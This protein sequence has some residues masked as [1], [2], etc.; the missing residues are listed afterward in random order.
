MTLA[1]VRSIWSG[2]MI[3]G[4]G[5]TDLYFFGSTGD[6]GTFAA[7]VRGL[8]ADLASA[9][10][11]GTTVAIDPDVFNIDEAT[12]D[13]I[14]IVTL[15][16]PPSPVTGT[17]AGEP[18]PPASQG[19][20]QWRTSG[21]VANRRVRGRTFLPALGEGGSTLGVPSSGTI[22]LVEDAC[23][24]FLSLA[25]QPMVWSRPV[26]GVRPGSM[27]DVQSATMWTQWAVLRSR[28]D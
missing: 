26:D 20:I 21:V 13:V 3:R 18:L 25:S 5:V 11:T 1:R 2:S 10:V 16:S 19:L 23:A 24:A 7:D 15:G 12:G 22:T 8:W 17:S 14:S 6:E 27:H 28:R 4:G 9:F